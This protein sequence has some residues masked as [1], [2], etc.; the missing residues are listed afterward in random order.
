MNLKKLTLVF[1]NKINLFLQ[2][3][4]FILIFY[5][6]SYIQNYSIIFP[7]DFFQSLD[8][9]TGHP[10]LSKRISSFIFFISIY[11]FFTLSLDKENWKK[12]LFIYNPLPGLFKGTILSIFWVALTFILL[13]SFKVVIPDGIIKDGEHII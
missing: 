9:L 8:Q 12:A 11:M 4:L 5:S 6:Y 1:S 10:F 13:L 2:L 3:G 7:D